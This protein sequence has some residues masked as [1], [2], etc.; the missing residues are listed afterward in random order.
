MDKVFIIAEAG[1]NHNGEIDLAYKLVDAAVEAGVDCIKFQTFI[2]DEE[3]SV[4]AEKASYQKETTEAEESQYEMSKRLELNFDDFRN[5]KVYCDEKNIM[6]LSTAF[7]NKS[8]DFLD[9]LGMKFWKIPSS[10]INNLP[11]LIKIAETG[12]DVILST[13]MSELKDIGKSL[14]ILNKNGAGNI[15]I[16]HCTTEYPAPLEEVNLR[17]MGV[18]RETFNCPVG[19]SDH[20][21]GIEATIAAVALG[22]KIIEK[23]FTLDKKMEGPDH[24]ASLEPKELKAM[25]EAIRKVEKALG[26]EKKII[27][28]S[29]R[30]NMIP[31][32]K[33]IVAY[34]DIQEGEVFSTENITTKRPGNG[35]SPM[36]WFDVLNK[37]ALRSFEK[38]EPIEL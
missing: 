17:A 35:L 29:E 1:V 3:T 13:G 5:L 24:K 23:H 22:A 26:Q 36:K 34:R 10:D 38:D 28:D 20:T 37:K 8:V 19:Y 15:S 33:S 21:E 2:T 25:V 27:T 12:K 31:A 6:F 11:Y 4:F 9:S 18:I 30:K 16:L 32:R 14:E 7:D